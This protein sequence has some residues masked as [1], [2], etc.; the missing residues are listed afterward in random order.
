MRERSSSV[1][2]ETFEMKLPIANAA[3]INAVFYYNTVRDS[4]GLFASRCF[5]PA[6][7]IISWIGQR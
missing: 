1:L 5:K 7:G 6:I 3:K 4:S 2:R